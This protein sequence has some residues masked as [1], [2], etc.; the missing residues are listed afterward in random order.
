M[1][2][3]FIFQISVQTTTS[4]TS[5]NKQSTRFTSTNKDPSMRTTANNNNRDASAAEYGIDSASGINRTL[6]IAIALASILLT[7][8]VEQ[9]LY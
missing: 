6:Q 3:K 9:L 8:L 7:Y 5:S 4:A 2:N 1:L